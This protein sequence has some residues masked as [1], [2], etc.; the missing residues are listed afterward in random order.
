M[1]IYLYPL[2]GVILWFIYRFVCVKMEPMCGDYSFTYGRIEGN[3]VNPDKDVLINAFNQ[4]SFK[5]LI[6]NC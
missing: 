2:Y 5:D 4:Q 3:W 1:R 6:A